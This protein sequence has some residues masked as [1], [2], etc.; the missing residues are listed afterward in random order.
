[1]QSGRHMYFNNNLAFL[2]NEFKK[3]ENLVNNY[4]IV[5][6]RNGP[7]F[8]N[9]IAIVEHKKYPIFGYHFRLEK[10]LFEETQHP[11][12]DRSGL[13]KMLV[14]SLMEIANKKFNNKLTNKIK[15][16]EHLNELFHTVVVSL[17]ESSDSWYL[18]SRNPD[19]LVLNDKKKPDNSMLNME[20]SSKRLLI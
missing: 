11:R 16:H 10:T 12:M 8:K 17:P 2:S 3:F 7:L 4:E 19:I 14:N 5:A 15:D 20:V 13:A 1:L 9:E 18:I 6:C